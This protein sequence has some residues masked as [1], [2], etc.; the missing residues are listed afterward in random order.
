MTSS[1]FS[2][3]PAVRVEGLNVRLGKRDVVEDLSFQ[4][5]AGRVT[6]V[7]GP[8]GAGKT[9]VLRALCGLIPFTGSIQLDSTPLSQLDRLER[10]RRIAYVPQRSSLTAALTVSEVV[11]LGRYAHQPGL[12]SLGARDQQAIA[13]AMKQTDVLGLGQRRYT[14]LSGGEQRRVLLARALAT[15]ASTI[16]LD[17]P[18]VF[19][20]IQHVLRLQ[21]LL[22]TLAQ[23]GRTILVV[24]HS[25]EEAKQC[26]DDGVLLSEGKL[27]TSGPIEDVI[28]PE[29]VRSVYQVTLSPATA[30]AFRELDP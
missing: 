24:L 4:A 13:D 27:V 3:R 12:L 30:M 8:N 11:E 18:T 20:D 22:K 17:E 26:A 10:A 1:A 5:H 25:L 6:A 14:E 7:M 16:L 23:R 15:G 19:L 9:T 21:R 29:V 28:T 2:E